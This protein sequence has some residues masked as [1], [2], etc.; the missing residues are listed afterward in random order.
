M[1]RCFA[2]ETG[3]WANPARL[4][5]NSIQN[6]NKN[7]PTG[8]FSCYFMVIPKG[9]EPLIFWMRTRRPG[10]LDDGTTANYSSKKAH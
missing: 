7:T 5:Q 6:N 10:P 9:V 4:P 1:R 2:S 3:H 8:H